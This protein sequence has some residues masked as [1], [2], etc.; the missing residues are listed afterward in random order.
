MDGAVA[1]AGPYSAPAL[2]FAGETA[3]TDDIIWW[4]VGRRPCLRGRARVGFL[5]PVQ[6]RGRRDLVR[7]DGVQGCL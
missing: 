4:V 6:R 5:V 1:L 2:G 3:E 7:L